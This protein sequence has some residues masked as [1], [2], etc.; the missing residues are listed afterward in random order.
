MPRSFHIPG[1]C[2][3]LVRFGGHVTDRPFVSLLPGSVA[4]S[5]I[6]PNSPPPGYTG[7]TFAASGGVI[8]PFPAGMA[9]Y[10]SQPSLFS[11][12]GQLFELGLATG[13]VTVSPRF[14]HQEV[15]P[16]D[17]GDQVPA[18]VHT[19]LADASIRMTLVHFDAA[20]L[21]VCCS[22]AMGGALVGGTTR[23]ALGGAVGPAGMP[24]GGGVPV[25]SSGNHY[26]SLN[27]LANQSVPPLPWRFRSCYL[28]GNPATFPLGANRQGVELNF[29]AIPYAPLV[30]TSQNFSTPPPD[31][32]VNEILSSGAVL[33]DHTPDMV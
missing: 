33:W 17:Y 15:I 2:L 20:V 18:E 31:N 21:S 32:R 1:E 4:L 9:P 7:G 26:V 3:V 11:S 8:L 14:R 27:V 28:D 23:P 12:P 5:P 10:T 16:D 6:N 24:L 13:D 25:G 22:E 30:P 29:R 19:R